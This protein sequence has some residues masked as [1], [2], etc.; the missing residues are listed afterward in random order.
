MSVTTME[1][2][3]CLEYTSPVFYNT[4]LFVFFEQFFSFAFELLRPLLEL[5]LEFQLNNKAHVRCRCE[6]HWIAYK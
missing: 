6:N 4:H 1:D 2:K 5:F 3:T